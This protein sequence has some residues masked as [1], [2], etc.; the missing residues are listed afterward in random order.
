MFGKLGFPGGFPVV[1]N[2]PASA[3]AAGVVGSIPTANLSC[4]SFK[5]V[6][7]DSPSSSVYR[8]IIK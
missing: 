6:E 5:Q 8:N 3:G 7:A 4:E 2:L 1:K